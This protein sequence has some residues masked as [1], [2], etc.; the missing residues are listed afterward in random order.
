MAGWFCSRSSDRRAVSQGVSLGT[1]RKT[2][3]KRLKRSECLSRKWDM[4]YGTPS[5]DQSDK[6]HRA[7]GWAVSVWLLVRTL[8]LF[9]PCPD[10]RPL[11]LVVRRSSTARTRSLRIRRIH[12]SEADA[13]KPL[14]SGFLLI[15]HGFLKVSARSLCGGLRDGR[16][17]RRE[18]RNAPDQTELLLKQ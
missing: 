16:R 13:L 18:W 15:D 11:A 10:S 1:N 7:G 9:E 6:H 12:Q 14:I 8:R 3:L 5:A 17:R 4:N 2:N